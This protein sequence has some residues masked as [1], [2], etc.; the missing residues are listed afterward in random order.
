MIVLGRLCQPQRIDQRRKVGPR[1]HQPPIAR[2]ARVNHGYGVARAN[3][4]AF[5][6]YNPNWAFAKSFDAQLAAQ[7]FCQRLL[8]L[9]AKSAV[10]P[11]G[12]A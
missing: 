3:P 4:Q 12:A 1:R 11:F 7:R 5:H 8:A 9:F 6:L 10:K 2:I